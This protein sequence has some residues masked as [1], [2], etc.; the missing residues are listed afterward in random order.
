MIKHDLFSP[1][2]SAVIVLRG[3]TIHRGETQAEHGDSTK[4]RFAG[5]Q[6]S[7]ASANEG[8]CTLC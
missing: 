7:P 2:C 1:F 4:E 6:A 8:I 3:N 5:A